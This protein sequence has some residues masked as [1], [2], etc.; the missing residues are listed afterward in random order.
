MKNPSPLLSVDDLHVSVDIGG[1]RQEVVRGVSFHLHEGEAMGLVGES[2]SGKT[3]TVSAISRLLPA[4]TRATGGSVQFRGEEL[5]YASPRRLAQLRGKDLG[6]VFQGSLAA[7]NPLMP[8][9]AQVG[10]PLRLHHLARPPAA[11]SAAEQM[12]RKLGIP[13]PSTAM[14][15]YPHE[16]SG[17]MRQRAMIAMAMIASPSLVIADEPTTALDATVQAQIVD[18]WGRLNREQGVA[19]ILVSHDLGVVAEICGTIAVMYAG[20]VVEVG[21][22]KIILTRPRHPYTQALL[23]SVPSA[24]T[25]TGKLPA[26]PGEPPVVGA[27]PSG[28]PFH[29]RCPWAIPACHE[30]EPVLERRGGSA[31]AC[32]VAQQKSSPGPPGLAPRALSPT[33]PNVRKSSPEEPLLMLDQVTRHHLRPS[34][35]P[36]GRPTRVH[37]VDDVSLS[38]RRSEVLGLAGESGCGKSTLA[39]CILRL[40]DIDS[41]RIIFNGRDIAQLRGEELRQLRKHI[42]AVFQ[43]PY[44]SLNP[45]ARVRDLIA[46]PLV[47][48]GVDSTSR[49]RRVSEVLDLVG[50]GQ[51]AAGRLPIELSGGQRQRV[52]IARAIAPNPQLIVAD[53]P[54]S[55]LDVSIQAQIVNLFQELRDAINLTLIFISH[56]LRIVRHISTNI[57]IMFLGNIVEYGPAEAVCDNALHPYTVALLSSV[58]GL[59]TQPKSRVILSGEPPSP[60]S[61]P[62]G[63]RFRTRCP[64]AR[65]ICAAQPPS[66]EATE[67]GHFVACHFPGVASMATQHP[68][69]IGSHKTQ[70]PI[71]GR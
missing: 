57:A 17:G 25:H 56:D 28:C 23:Q 9:G 44:E 24:T 47:A 15:R 60:S 65:D 40:I 49:M 33:T 34:A 55:A 13:D 48:H 39:R 1:R 37:A 58:P 70:T 19:L 12:L 8:I 63:C 6:M 66:L 21:P 5:L 22:T 30:T 61:P 50:L 46:E 67:A 27:L 64:Y 62:S 54:I 42:Q 71:F 52:G 4:G 10:E 35:W 11:A 7:L 38:V 20:R 43:D 36:L 32:W 53:E 69:S 29:P 45:R 2:G 26:I 68:V 16:F 3:L 18:I 41:G 31:V 59:D 14:H 51:R